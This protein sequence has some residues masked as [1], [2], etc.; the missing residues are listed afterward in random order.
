MDMTIH[1]TQ[2]GS[3]T[4]D[5]YGNIKEFE[6]KYFVTNPTSKSAA[7]QA[8]LDDSP[9]SNG[10]LN[11]SGVRFDSYDDDGNMEISVLYEGNDN[12]GGDS[13]DDENSDPTVSFDCSGGTKHI[14][15][16]ISQRKAYPSGADDTGGAIGWNGKPGPEMEIT[17]VDVPTGQLRE[18]YT[19]IFRMS[20]ITTAK[21]RAWNSLVGKVNSSSFKGWSPGEVMFLGCSFSGTNKG[22][23]KV[24]VQFNFSIQ[25]NESS[26]K[27][28]GVSCGSKQGFQCIWAM[29]D[30]AKGNDDTPVANIKGVYVATVCESGNFGTL[31][32]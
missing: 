21:K 14:T 1:R 17:G 20:E 28:N 4:W 23:S 11:R 8:V 9:V 22:S 10:D 18:S 30:T 32:I 6:I 16:A 12:S 26:A 2:E 13:S 31:G 15:H 24:S 25:E 3:E 27:I 19:K 29:S 5:A 7:M